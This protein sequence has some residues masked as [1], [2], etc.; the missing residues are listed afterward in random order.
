MRKDYIKAAFLFVIVALFLKNQSWAI[1]LSVLGISG[2]LG[3]VYALYV[4]LT[5]NTPATHKKD[6]DNTGFDVESGIDHPFDVGTHGSKLQYQDY[7]QKNRN[8]DVPNLSPHVADTIH[9]R[10]D[11]IADRIRHREF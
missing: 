10:P 2:G 7:F 1:I 11:V 8:Y 9:D 4:F 6:R 3:G 5:D